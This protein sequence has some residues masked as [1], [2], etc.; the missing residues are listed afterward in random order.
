[1]Y[2]GNPALQSGDSRTVSAGLTLDGIKKPA[3]PGVRLERCLRLQ[4]QDSRVKTLMNTQV[5][6]LQ[7]VSDHRHL[8][9]LLMRVGIESRVAG[10]LLGLIAFP[11]L[12][13][14]GSAIG[15][16]WLLMI[17]LVGHGLFVILKPYPK[18]LIVDCILK[19]CLG[20]VLIVASQPQTYVI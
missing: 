16:L 18:G 13:R 7:E 20:C 14:H 6:Q 15:V 1:L 8:G 4:T 9:K 2:S 3:H 11:S 19:C 5:T 17:A 10:L 12:L